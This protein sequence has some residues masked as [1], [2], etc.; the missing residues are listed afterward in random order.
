MCVDFCWHVPCIY[1]AHGDQ[2]RELDPL[3][4]EIQTIVSYHVG[5]GNQIQVLSKNSQCSKLLSHLSSPDSM[6]TKDT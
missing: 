6:L 1:S 3:E 2:K 5:A 4:L